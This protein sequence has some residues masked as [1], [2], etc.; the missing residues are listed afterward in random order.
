MNNCKM[1][2]KSSGFETNGHVYSVCAINPKVRCVG[3]D[4]DKT[5]CPFWNV[6]AIK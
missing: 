4:N 2:I 3:K 6:V 1:S 5:R